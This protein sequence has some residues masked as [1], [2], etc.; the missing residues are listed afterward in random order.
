M[1]ISL[2]DKQKKAIAQSNARIN[3]W[4]G[5]VR[6]G[7]TYSSI[8][9]FIASLQQEPYGDVMILGYNR[10]TIQRNVLE[11]L[12]QLLGEPVPSVGCKNTKLFGRNVYFVGAHNESSIARIQGSTLAIA[13]VDEVAKLPKSVWSMLMTRLSVKNAI[14][15]G[16]AN[17]DGP[18]HWLKLDY[19]D[20]RDKF[21]L[22]DWQFTLDDNP[23]LTEDY[24][25]AIK[26][27]LTGVW[28][29][30][31]I[32]GEWAIAEG[33]VY[34]MFNSDY[35]VIDDNPRWNQYTIIGVDYGTTN[36]FAAIAIGFNNLH[37]PFLVVEKELYYDSSKTGVQ[38]TDAQYA[39]MLEDFLANFPNN[40][41]VYLDPSAA[42]FEQ[43][44]KRRGIKV[45]S[46]N[47]D[48]TSGIRYVSSLIYKGDL[49]IH[50]SCK[51]L[52]NE[53]QGYVWDLSLSQKGKDAPL[54]K[55]DHALDAMRYAIYSHFGGKSFLDPVTPKM[56][57]QV[58]HYK[59]YDN[60]G[61]FGGGAL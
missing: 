47:N 49:Q 8:I 2:S 56:Q 45:L 9:R 48:V 34:D 23:S 12:Y 50:N 51:N 44:L 33:S 20:R 41:Y 27:E 61:W 29:R 16:T 28:Y 25:N 36:P 59:S 18:S 24:K 6:S 37:R 22:Q 7:K 40:K 54:K 42:S 19:L 21:D 55:N 5:S 32:M 26:S 10:D 52:I 39:D 4:I 58:T 11:P 38:K 60:Y 43:E 17:P 1:R 46:A 15:F 53:I 3:L 31:L 57:E 13:Y 30:R 14:L 35:H